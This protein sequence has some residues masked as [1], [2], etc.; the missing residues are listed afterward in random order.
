MKPQP[1]AVAATKPNNKRKMSNT[2]RIY[3]PDGETPYTKSVSL[4]TASTHVAAGDQLAEEAEA[5]LDYHAGRLS[6][7]MREVRVGGVRVPWSE[8]RSR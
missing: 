6:R 8:W 7:R 4:A 5:L 2:I 3:A 1:R